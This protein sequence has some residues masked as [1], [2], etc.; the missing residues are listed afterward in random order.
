[1]LTVDQV[2]SPRPWN[3]LP[4]VDLVRNYS[5]IGRNQ[6]H[7]ERPMASE[8]SSSFDSTCPENNKQKD[9]CTPPSHA[10]SDSQIVSAVAAIAKEKGI[11]MAKVATAWVLHKGIW[12]IVGLGST[13]RIDEAVASV[14]VKL[15]ESE[16][17]RL[18][19]AYVSKPVAALW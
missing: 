10:K 7:P 19:E 8:Y 14:G 6:P 15:S 3:S 2:V 16:I 1:M 13:K 17:K 11:S 12:P 4:P 9:A 18:E 5:C